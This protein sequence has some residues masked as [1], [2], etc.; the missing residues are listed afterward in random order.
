MRF[1]VELVVLSC[2]TSATQSSFD[3]GYNDTVE[4]HI[5]D[6]HGPGSVEAVSEEVQRRREEAYDA[7]L[8][9]RKPT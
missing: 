8:A 6:I 1:G 3:V 4:T 9:E 2:F 7:W 5:D